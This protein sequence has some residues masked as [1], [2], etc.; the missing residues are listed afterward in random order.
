MPHSGAY[1]PHCKEQLAIDMHMHILSLP[2][3]KKQQQGN[4]QTKKPIFLLAGHLSS[5]AGGRQEGRRD[6]GPL[7]DC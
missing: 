3:K 7:K 4:K 1:W 6:I 5:H 2:K